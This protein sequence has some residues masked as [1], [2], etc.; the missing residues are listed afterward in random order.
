MQH[1]Y[2]NATERVGSSVVKTYA[3]PRAAQRAQVERRAL[4]HLS[5]QVP[6]PAVVVAMQAS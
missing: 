6:V 4:K 1:G 2:T 3:G 5:G